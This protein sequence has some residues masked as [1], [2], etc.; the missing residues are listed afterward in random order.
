MPGGLQFF[1]QLGALLEQFP[2]PARDK[3]ALHRFAEV[4]IGPGRTPSKDQRLSPDT[5][6][7]LQDA[8]ADGPAQV[9]ADQQDVFRADFDRHDGYLLGGFGRYGT[10]YRLRAV[11][12]QIGLGAFSSSQTIFALTTTDHSRQPLSGSADYVLHLPSALPVNEGWSLTVY[13]LQGFLITN[14]IGRYQFSD[15]SQLTR[16]ADGSAD[17][18]LQST[19]PT[20]TAQAA[21]WLPTGAGQGFEVMWRLLA[22]RSGQIP[23]I[24][25]GSGWQPPAI[26]VVP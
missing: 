17:V 23:G 22:P 16:N 20:V 12:S 15:T 8:V 7:G 4:G 11:V 5:L 18:Y 26:T 2:P 24:L 9:M 10:D 3:A 6:Q 19:E 14:P 21:N 25:D 1:D 13:N